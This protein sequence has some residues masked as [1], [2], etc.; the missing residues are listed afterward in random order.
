MMDRQIIGQN[1]NDNR[2]GNNMHEI[3][4]VTWK[5]YQNQQLFMTGLKTQILDQP[6]FKLSF[7]LTH[8]QHGK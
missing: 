1:E 7:K 3:I 6:I 8:G 4:N 2:T 5:I